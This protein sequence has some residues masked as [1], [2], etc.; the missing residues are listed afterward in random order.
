MNYIK[1]FYGA[2]QSLSLS[3]IPFRKSVLELNSG[4]N[5]INFSLISTVVVCITVNLHVKSIHR[6][7]TWNKINANKI[8]K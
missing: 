3:E 7:L 1:D 2:L 5:K 8:S 4:I 6:S